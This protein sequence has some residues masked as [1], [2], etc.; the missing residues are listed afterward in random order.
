MDALGSNV[1]LSHRT[2]EI[3]RI[4]PRMND[5]INEEWLG[6]KGRFI[7]DGLKRQRLLQP[8][9]KKNDAIVYV[10]SLSNAIFYTFQI[11]KLFWKN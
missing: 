6:D 4:I 1:V 2:G 5:D 7:C 9:I 3:L 11:Y 8:M 10:F